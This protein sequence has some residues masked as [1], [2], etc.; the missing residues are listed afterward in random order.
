MYK[1]IKSKK[2]INGDNMLVYIENKKHLAQVLNLLD[3]ANI[4]Y[5]TNL[6]AHYSTVLITNINNKI[7]KIINN[8]KVILLTFFIEEDILN[9][10]LVIPKINNLKIITNLSILNK[11]EDV[12]YIPKT[13]PYIITKKNKLI[14]DKYKL[15]KN[16]KRLIIIDYALEYIN[17]VEKI[18]EN[19]NYEI[20]YIGYRKVTKEESE[21]LKKYIW[22]KY[23]DYINFNYLCNISS[24]VIIFNN[25]VDIRYL[26]IAI[27]THTEL[28]MIDDN[29]H[30]NYLISCKHYY[31]F[32]NIKNL[33]IKMQKLFTERTSS[34]NDNAYFLIS[35]N[36]ETEYLNKLKKFLK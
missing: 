31:G 9:N 18:K 4:S 25:D 1:K 20:I 11:N 6:K 24:L 30:K 17:E 36:T 26:Y 22:I 10:K 34:L 15:I 3:L 27:L 19:Y 35:K 29:I 32:N 14:Y 28:F 21:I 33:L 13:I 23:I 8:K 2:N 7:L 16:K 5:T 12:Y